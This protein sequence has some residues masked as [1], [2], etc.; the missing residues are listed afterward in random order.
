MTQ[1]VSASVDA[2][3]TALQQ[4][5][6]ILIHDAADREG[7]TD[8]VYPAAA[9]TPEDVTRLRN[10]AGG[11]VCVAVSASVATAFE[12]PFISQALQHPATTGE[13]SYDD[14]SS[15]SLSVN[16]RDTYTGITDHDRALT[17][18]QVAAAA[19]QVRTH[20]YDV[21]DFADEFR[22]PGHVNLLRAAPSL[23]DRQGHTELAIAL[24]EAADCAPAAVVCEMLDDATGGALSQAAAVDYAERHGLE[25][26]EGAAILSAFQ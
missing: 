17:I 8:L 26:I 19:E 25:Y 18:T 7:E 14:R 22:S 9:V 6:P 12:L 16:H 20:G 23:A 1:Q 11:L 5:N 15:F 4:G 24:A 3:I 21:S 10:D 2:A 13:V